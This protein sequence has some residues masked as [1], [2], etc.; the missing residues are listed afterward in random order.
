VGFEPTTFS[1]ATRHST[2]ELHPQVLKSFH[3]NDYG[4]PVSLVSNPTNRFPHATLQRYVVTEG[5]DAGY[6]CRL[7]DRPRLTLDTYRR[8]VLRIS[9]LFSLN[10]GSK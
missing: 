3:P 10:S 7:P 2:T 8:R 4:I 1:L 5:R 9:I 6:S